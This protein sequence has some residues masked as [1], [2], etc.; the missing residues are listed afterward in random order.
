M[1]K[2]TVRV[3]HKVTRTRTKANNSSNTKGKENQKRC[4]SCGR[5]M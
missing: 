2:A 3:T 5:Y 4:P 1:A